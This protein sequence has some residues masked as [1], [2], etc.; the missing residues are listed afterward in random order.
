MASKERNVYDM[1]KFDGNNFAL[2]KEQ[3]QDVLVQKKQRLP[4]MHATCTENLGMTQIEWDE[5]DAMARATIRLH[6]AESVY[7]MILECAT[8]YGTWHK[9]INTYEKNIASNKVFLMRKLYN[10]RMKES[11]SAAV[12]INEFDSLFAQIHAQ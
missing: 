2:W 6:L 8:T 10:L 12:H 7:F 4:I 5:L 11:S 1:R 9:L 3:M